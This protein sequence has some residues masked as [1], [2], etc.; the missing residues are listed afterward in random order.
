MMSS[1]TS[2][3][4]SSAASGASGGAGPTTW[5]TRCSTTSSTTF[6]DA[7]LTLELSIEQLETAILEGG[8]QEDV[9]RRIHKLKAIANKFRATLGPVR[10][11]VNRWHKS[12]HPTRSPSSRST[13]ATSTTIPPAPTSSTQ[14]VHHPHQRPLP[15]LHL[16]VEYPD[17]QG[18]AAPHGGL[19]DLHPAHFPNGSLRDE[20]RV[21]PR[22]R[23]S[24][25]ATSCCGR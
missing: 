2:P 18:G 12:E 3:T 25:T 4:A 9:K 11:A 21:H 15:A 17:Q 16:G 19:D 13:C 8:D 20:L 14:R 7:L 24:A 6:T 23:R 10:D 5:P 22:A 1:R